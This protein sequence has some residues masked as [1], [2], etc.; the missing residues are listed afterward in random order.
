MP[1]MQATEP[2]L[3]HVHCSCGC[4]ELVPEHVAYLTGGKSFEHWL[5]GRTGRLR[6]I[7]VI[8][9]AR[10][11]PVKVRPD[12][13][14]D[15]KRHRGQHHKVDHAKRKAMNRLRMLYPEAYEL[16]YMEERAKVGLM[17]LPNT[18]PRHLERLVET[19]EASL[20]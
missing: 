3:G 18:D 16:L 13:K 10:R 6:E 4:G 19:V 2:V 17:P 15:K 7:E 11:M 12:K 8:E 9:R 20:A 5:A 1:L 14:P